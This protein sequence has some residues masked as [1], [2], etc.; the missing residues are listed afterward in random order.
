M[1]EEKGVTNIEVFSKDMIPWVE[2]T[3]NTH[4]IYT[5]YYMTQTLRWTTKYL[6]GKMMLDTNEERNKIL[7]STNIDPS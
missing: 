5:R 6:L 7:L 3:S 1:K 2:N 4:T